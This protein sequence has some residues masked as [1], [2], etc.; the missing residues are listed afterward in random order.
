[1][2]KNI[3]MTENLQTNKKAL[4]INFS[5]KLLLEQKLLQ[6]SDDN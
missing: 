5:N 6:N 4:K 2:Q 3:Q 1:M